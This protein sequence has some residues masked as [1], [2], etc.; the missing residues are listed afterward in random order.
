MQIPL[1]TAPPSLR[2]PGGPW[3][4]AWRVGQILRATLVRA[5]TPDSAALRIAGRLVRAWGRDLPPL[6]AGESLRLRVEAL[7]R[8]PLLRVLAPESVS[9]STPG[10]TA[11]L[12]TS[13]PRAGEMEPLLTHLATMVREGPFGSP[14]AVALPGLARALL[15]VLRT[16]ADLARAEGLRGALRDSGIFL[17][18]RLLA[19]AGEAA[20]AGDLKGALWRLLAALKD[21]GAKASHRG[22]GELTPT[23]GSDSDSLHAEVEGALARLQL[24]QLAALPR[25][26]APAQWI[27]TLPVGGNAPAYVLELQIRGE[28]ERGAAPDAPRAWS[29][30]LHLDLPRLGAVQARIDLQGEQVAATLWAECE[31]TIAA[32]RRHL[33]HLEAELRGAGL[34]VERLGCHR[35]PGPRPALPPPA[36]PL[37][38]LE[39]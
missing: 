26:Q 3:T 27:F 35:G 32:V 5:D 38:D 28:D 22:D 33:P 21:A 15:A 20:L 31:A 4:R 12:R 30:L 23:T 17:E 34:R 29:V 6:Q 8:T 11:A 2:V 9:E 36:A 19:G 25:A 14:G 7:G 24:H 37:V 18:A 13:L 10:I 16:P 39:A 1:P